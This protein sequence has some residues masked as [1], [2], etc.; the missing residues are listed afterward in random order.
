M[1]TVIDMMGPDYAVGHVFTLDELGLS[2][3]PINETGK[4]M[5]VRLKEAVLS[6]LG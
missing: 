1:N 4:I 6:V 2:E 3:W 5:K